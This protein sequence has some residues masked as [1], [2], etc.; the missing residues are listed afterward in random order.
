M[1]GNRWFQELPVPEGDPA[2]PIHP[3][4]VLPVWEGLHYDPFSFPSKRFRSGLVLDVHGL[5]HVEGSECLVRPG[6]QL[7]QVL[8]LQL[9]HADLPGVPLGSPYCVL[10]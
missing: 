1:E 2:G 4:L 7:G 9:G 5:P 3:D 8:H 6:I 10:G